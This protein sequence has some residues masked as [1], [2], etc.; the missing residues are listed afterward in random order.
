M[1]RLCLRAFLNGNWAVL[2]SSINAKR[3]R[4]RKRMWRLSWRSRRLGCRL[5]SRYCERHSISIMEGLIVLRIQLGIAR[6]MVW[7]IWMKMAGLIVLNRWPRLYVGGVCTQATLDHI[8]HNVVRVALNSGH[9]TPHMPRGMWLVW[10]EGLATTHTVNL[11]NR[12]YSARAGPPGFGP[13]WCYIVFPLDRLHLCKG[14]A[15]CRCCLP[16]QGTCLLVLYDRNAGADAPA[17]H[18]LYRLYPGLVR[19]QPGLLPPARRKARQ[20]SGGPPAAVKVA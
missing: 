12:T 15:D 6:L 10:L 20:C 9:T 19:R 1:V 13:R 18:C 11:G 16:I 3:R 4:K 8:S 14:S 7:W 2:H 17:T 5:T